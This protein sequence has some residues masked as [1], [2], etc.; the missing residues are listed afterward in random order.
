[1]AGIFDTR[2]RGEWNEEW[3]LSSLYLHCLSV[4][5]PLDSSEPVSAAYEHHERE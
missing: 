4:M 2:Q 1:M 3:S 5:S